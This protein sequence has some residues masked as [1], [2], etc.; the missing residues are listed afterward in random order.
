MWVK[1]CVEAGAETDAE[2]DVEADVDVDVEKEWE[3]PMQGDC[4]QLYIFARI[5]VTHSDKL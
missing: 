3:I 4:C 2:V 5:P 1:V